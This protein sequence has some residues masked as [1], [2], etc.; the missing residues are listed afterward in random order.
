M[1]ILYYNEH[2]TT[3]HIS[4]TKEERGEREREREREREGERGGSPRLPVRPRPENEAQSLKLK[5]TVPPVKSIGSM[6]LARLE[7]ALI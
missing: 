7:D 6:L 4:G 2:C 5:L 1:I 3:V